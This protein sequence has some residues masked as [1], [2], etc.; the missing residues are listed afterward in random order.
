FQYANLLFD[1]APLGVG[2]Q[3]LNRLVYWLVREAKRPV[4]HGHH[5]PS[6][7]IQEPLYGVFRAGVHSAK[8]IGMGSGDGKQ[9]HLRLQALADLA[10]AIEVRGVSGVINR[11]LAGRPDVSAP[12]AMQARLTACA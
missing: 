5:P 9:R 7:Q 2:L 1:A 4:V 6:A 11:M 3:T 8:G 12:A 10:E